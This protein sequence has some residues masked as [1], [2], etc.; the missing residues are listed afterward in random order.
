[1]GLT[2]TSEPHETIPGKK[3]SDQLV[4]DRREEIVVVIARTIGPLHPE[5][6]GGCVV[7]STPVQLATRQRATRPAVFFE[8]LP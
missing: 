7:Q 1:M 2:D 8:D 4:W 5:E 6:R 3:S